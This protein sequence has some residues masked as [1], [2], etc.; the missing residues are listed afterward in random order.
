ME[1]NAN[2]QILTAEK[3]NEMLKTLEISDKGVLINELR[4]IETRATSKFPRKIFP[5]YIPEWF[6]ED[7]NQEQLHSITL[8]I[9]QIVEGELQILKANVEM[10]EL[11]RTKRLWTEPPTEELM[12]QNPLLDSEVPQ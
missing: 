3:L 12:D 5:C 6:W 4:F 7:E 1:R 2:A 9:L 10:K 11:G 8:N